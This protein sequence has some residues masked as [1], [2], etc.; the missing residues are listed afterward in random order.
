MQR[1]PAAAATASA[2]AVASMPICCNWPMGEM[3]APQKNSPASEVAR[4]PTRGYGRLRHD[5]PFLNH[6]PSVSFAAPH[7]SRDW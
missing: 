5:R 4:P 7:A 3:I 2:I 1:A 6:A